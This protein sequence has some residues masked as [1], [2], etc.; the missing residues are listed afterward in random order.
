M[1]RLDG[2]TSPLPIPPARG[3]LA[4]GNPT[5]V[6][7]GWE[8]N[9]CAAVLFVY[10][11]AFALPVFDDTGILANHLGVRPKGAV[12]GWQAFLVGWFVQRIGWFANVAIWIGTILLAR[13][14]PLAAAI[15]GVLA[16]GLGSIYLVHLA[17]H[18]LLS[19]QSF[20]AGYFCWLASAVLLAGGGLGLRWLGPGRRSLIFAAATVTTGV[21]ALV[22]AE[23]FIIVTTASPSEAALTD[24]LRSGDVVAP[25]RRQEART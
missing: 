8:R 13:R 23:H 14:R 5:A 4:G 22:T 3:P 16:L 19:P 24:R 20:S 9:F 10:L 18:S 17:D 12:Y 11:F 7:R 6:S 25:R 15:A 2:T 21:A 1:T